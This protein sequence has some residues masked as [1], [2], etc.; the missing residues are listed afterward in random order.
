MLRFRSKA[1]SS[2]A[3]SAAKI[4]SHNNQGRGGSQTMLPSAKNTTM[5]PAITGIKV[6]VTNRFMT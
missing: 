4:T 6:N 1:I 2:P 3:T 5:T